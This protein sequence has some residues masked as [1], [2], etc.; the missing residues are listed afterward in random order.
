M[1]A[2]FPGIEELSDG[3]K[4]IRV[5]AVNPKTGRMQE[6]DKLIHGT[7]TDAVKLREQWRDEIRNA[8]QVAKPQTLRFFLVSWLRSRALSVKLSTATTYAE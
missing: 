3:R 1:K 7:L 4:R 5:R 8:D 2:K 6:V